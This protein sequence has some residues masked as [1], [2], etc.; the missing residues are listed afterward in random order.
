M[1]DKATEPSGPLLWAEPVRNQSQCLIWDSARDRRQFPNPCGVRLSPRALPS[2]SS[3]ALG[4]LPRRRPT[5]CRRPLGAGPGGAEPPVRPS[6]ARLP[7]TSRTTPSG[8]RTRPACPPPAGPAASRGRGCWPPAEGRAQRAR[9]ASAGPRPAGTQ[10][11]PAAPPQRRNGESTPT[12]LVLPLQASNT[13]HR[14]ARDHLRPAVPAAQW[15]PAGPVA[16]ESLVRGS[17]AAECRPP[18]VLRLF[19]CYRCRMF[20]LALASARR[21]HPAPTSQCFQ[22]SRRARS[23]RSAPRLLSHV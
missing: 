9:A 10:R 1:R 8:S 16:Y 3:S 15:S 17:F 13:R 7:P 12:S 20:H 14:S 23:D 4:S 22:I 5:R 19:D 21:L 2:R 11:N 18:A 6:V